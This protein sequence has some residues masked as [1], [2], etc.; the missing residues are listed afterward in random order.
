MVKRA[1][2]AGADLIK[3]QK[4]DVESFHTPE[5]LSSF[6][7]SP[8]GQTLREYR[9]GVE[10]S[11]QLLEVLDETCRKCGIEW[12]ASVLDFPSFLT[13]R[14]FCP[15][16]IKV[17]STISDHRDFHAALAAVY[18]GPLVVS[19]GATD[20]HYT[21]Y[22]LRT[23][24]NNEVLY[25]LHCVSAYPTPGDACNVAV[26]RGYDSLARNN[27]KVI[28]GYSSHDLGSLGSMLA[29]A[30]GARMIEKHVKLN[31]VPWVHFDKV[32]MDLT[33]NEF[34]RFVDDVRIA[35]QMT[36]DPQKRVYECEHHKYIVAR[37]L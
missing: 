14:R 17:P 10:L 30:S 3:I 16:L 1:K 8:F 6:Y 5:Q 29:V 35:E 9:R 7:W 18:T 32:A 12:F 13:I 24:A 26:V 36:G 25:L 22:V 37:Q 33:T 28:P 4:R 20:A 15:R 31:D 23:F 21:E 27:P 19:T 34:S 2:D 11:E